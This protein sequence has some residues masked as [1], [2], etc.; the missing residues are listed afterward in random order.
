MPGA[1][2]ILGTD[3][4]AVEYSPEFAGDK[5]LLAIVASGLAPDTNDTYLY[6]GMRGAGGNTTWNGLPGYPVEICQAGADTP[7]SPLIAA[8]L[9][10][11]SDYS[12]S[13]APSRHVYASW[14]DGPGG[15]PSDDVYRLD[16]IICRQL[17]VTGGTVSSIAYYGTAYRGKLLAW[18]KDGS[19]R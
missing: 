13:D 5:V 1:P 11:P 7:G 14:S 16:D 4:F 6:I 9:A 18:G 17:Y 15:S 12:G 8:D 10:L 3:V 2:A 19:P